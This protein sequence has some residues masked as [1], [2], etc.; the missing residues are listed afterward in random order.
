[1]SNWQFAFEWLILPGIGVGLVCSVGL[2]AAKRF[3]P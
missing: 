2:W 3:I 1:M